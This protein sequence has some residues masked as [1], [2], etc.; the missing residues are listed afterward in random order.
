M[1]WMSNRIKVMFMFVCK[2]ELFYDFL[3]YDLLKSVN[4]T[5][6][7]KKTDTIQKLS[8]AVSKKKKAHRI[9][10]K[11]CHDPFKPALWDYLLSD[12]IF[13]GIRFNFT[14]WNTSW[15]RG[16]KLRNRSVFHAIKQLTSL[17]QI[18]T[19]ITNLN[20][21][22]IKLRTPPQNILFRCK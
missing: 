13:K 12:F 10:N 17:R 18:Y 6:F 20:G 11:G 19:I 8:L 7:N 4:L 1:F 15:G 9:L 2:L 3:F 21:N 5:I 22:I 16:I 14:R